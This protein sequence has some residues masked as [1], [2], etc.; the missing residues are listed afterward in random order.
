M[1]GAGRRGI[2]RHR[3]VGDQTAMDR[4]G[5]SIG[6]RPRCREDSAGRKGPVVVGH[7]WPG[8]RVQPL[9]ER[10]RDPDF[11]ECPSM[12]RIGIAGIGFMGMIA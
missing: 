3:L 12:I 9:I 7:R 6:M 4:V 10:T 8:Q 1:D 5:G 11:E 2:V